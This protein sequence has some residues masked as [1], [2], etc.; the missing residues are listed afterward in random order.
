MAPKID[1]IKTGKRINYLMRPN[2]LSPRDIQKY[3]GLSCVQTVYHWT[4]GISVPKIENLYTL[5]A[6]FNVDLES[7]IVGDRDEFWD[8]DKVQKNKMIT[9]MIF[10]DETEKSLEKG[11]VVTEKF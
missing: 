3:I 10:E 1:V 5:S 9:Q 2:N 4:S 8:K 11:R 6:L 7:I